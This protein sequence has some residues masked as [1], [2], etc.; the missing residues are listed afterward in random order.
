[1]M[2]KFQAA[3]WVRQSRGGIAIT[4]PTALRE[5]SCECYQK[6]HDVFVRLLPYTAKKV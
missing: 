3:G 1:M 6:V 5:V 4:D 2:K